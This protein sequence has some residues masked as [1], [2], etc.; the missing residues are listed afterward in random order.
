MNLRTVTIWTTGLVLIFTIFLWI[1]TFELWRTPLNFLFAFLFLH[2]S[3]LLINLFFALKLERNVP[4]IC[5][6]NIFVGSNRHLR[7]LDNMA[8]NSACF[9]SRSVCN[10]WCHLFWRNDDTSHNLSSLVYRCLLRPHHIARRCRLLETV[11]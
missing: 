8:S 9:D 1:Y 7:N 10:D 4:Q 11:A 6:P 3:I 5:F 2:P